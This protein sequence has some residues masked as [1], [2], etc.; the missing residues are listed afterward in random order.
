MKELGTKDQISDRGGVFKV[1]RY[2]VSLAAREVFLGEQRIKLSWRCFGAMELLVQAGG[3]I[4]EREDF[5][6]HIWPDVTVD[7]SNLSHCIAQLRK[8]LGEPPEGGLIETVP[9]QGYRL[10]QPAELI[11]VASFPTETA[12]TELAPSN[13]TPAS[14]V[15]A[16]FHR[17]S[18]LRWGVAAFCALTLCGIVAGVSVWHR[19]SVHQQA[20]SLTSE[21]FR[22]LRQGHV[23]QVGQANS[24]FRRAIELDSKL[25]PAYAGLAEGMARSGDS[26]PE[27]PGAMAARALR[28]DRNCAECKAI[29]GWI[30]MTREWRFRE[31]LAYLNDAV[32][33]KPRDAQIRLWHAQMFA[34]AGR[35]E[36]ALKEINYAVALD[37]SRAPSITMRAGILYLSGRFE[38]AISTARQALGLQPDS[39]SA[40]DWI[41]RSFIQLN[42][43]EEAIAARA[44]VNAHYVGLSADSQIELER[45]WTAAYKQGGLHGLVETL[46]SE[47]AAKPSIDHQ[48]YERATW[49]MWI[50]DREG[51][52]S[53]LER[54]FDFHPFQCTYLAVDPSFKPLRSEPRFR[55]LLSRIGI[56][57]VLAEP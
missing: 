46:L 52:L 31:A 8:Q 50:G 48:R 57:T 26:Q 27:Q 49:R 43:V 11:P 21:G 18:R 53:E 10:S 32:S 7:E 47:T 6:R 16:P 38:E 2:R 23:F 25:A 1:G 29:A 56:S 28:L 35:L 4:V 39:N 19:W 14:A 37:T 12:D 44:A 34:S 45:R 36:Q 42:R 15:K 33:Q 41:Y 40:W 5:F 30:L 24:L 55:E 22:L 9:R 17:R 13:G 3:E 51:A 20:R 54:V